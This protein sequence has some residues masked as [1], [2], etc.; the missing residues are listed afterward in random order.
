[1]DVGVCVCLCV[2]YTGFMVIMHV[3]IKTKPFFNDGETANI[4]KEPAV[5]GERTAEIF[6]QCETFYT[7]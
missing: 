5:C 3:C 4:L 7:A 2:Y 1:M 6:L